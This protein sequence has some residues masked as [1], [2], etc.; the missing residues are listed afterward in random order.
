V[1]VIA[2]CQPSVPVLAAAALMAEAKDPRQPRSLT[3]M[4]GPIDTRQSPTVPNDLAMRN[5]MMWFR[6]NVRHLSTVPASIRR[7]AAG[8]PGFLHDSTALHQHEPRPD[9]INAPHAASSSILS[10]VTT[11][12]IAD[13]PSLPSTTE[14]PRVRI[15]DLRRFYPET[16]EVV[17]EAL[18]PTWRV[19]Q[20]GRT[21]SIPSSSGT[22]QWTVEGQARRH[23]RVG[24]RPGKAA[25][26][27]QHP[28]R[29]RLLGSSRASASHPASSTAQV[30]EQ[31]MPPQAGDCGSATTSHPL[32]PARADRARFAGRRSGVDAPPSRVSPRNGCSSA[33]R[34]R[35]EHR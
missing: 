33:D 11:S 19:D 21:R 29:R 6:Q 1:H 34:P 3:L 4:G 9:I 26:T 8:Y 13:R 18:L 15:M 27:P 25:L 32:R 10:K 16:I 31:I 20:I 23:L 24:H 17:S 28:A 30:L 14:Y 7:D 35:A 5:S 2:V 22:G 12:D